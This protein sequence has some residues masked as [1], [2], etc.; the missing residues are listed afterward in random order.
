M[1]RLCILAVLSAVA[2]ADEIPDD[3][4]AQMEAARAEQSGDTVAALGL[5]ELLQ[6]AP[7]GGHSDWI[8]D[9][10]MGLDTVPAM[11]ALDRGEALYAVRELYARR[12]EP[13]HQFYGAEGVAHAG[14]E[15]AQT[16]DRSGAQLQDLMRRLAD[17][18]VDAAAIEESVRTAQQSLVGIETAARTA[19]LTPEAPRN[20]AVSEP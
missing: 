9:I 6:T 11:A 16:I 4:S 18:A 13:L 10:R 7:P 17:N 5:A 1:R 15:L 12:F 20:A 2:C 3:V 14:A 8:R 19:G